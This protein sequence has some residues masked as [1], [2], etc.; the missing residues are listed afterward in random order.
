MFTAGILFD[1]P[2]RRAGKVATD[3]VDPQRDMR[4]HRVIEEDG[5]RLSGQGLEL[6]HP[7]RLV[8]RQQRAHDRSGRARW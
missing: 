5:D 3:L 6:E 1:I 7:D 8:G 4:M 2:F